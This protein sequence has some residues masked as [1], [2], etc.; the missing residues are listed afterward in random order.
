ML[1]KHAE[2]PCYAPC[3]C[4][5]PDSV[6]LSDTLITMNAFSPAVELSRAVKHLVPFNAFET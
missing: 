6:S 2:Q 3:A 1:N 5:S 4:N